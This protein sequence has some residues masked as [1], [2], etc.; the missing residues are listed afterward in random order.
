MES[1]ELQPKVEN[2][3]I[4]FR[5]KQLQILS[6]DIFRTSPYFSE[7]VK[8]S[9]GR[10][11]LLDVFLKDEVIEYLESDEFKNL[12][13]EEKKRINETL[14]IIRNIYNELG[15]EHQNRN[16]ISLYVE[17]LKKILASPINNEFNIT[18]ALA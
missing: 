8:N 5:S 2:N 15:H 12:T 6:N 14:G 3:V 7:Q 4:Q 11:K 13:D 10:I 9:D 1:P 18:R 16:K 17:D